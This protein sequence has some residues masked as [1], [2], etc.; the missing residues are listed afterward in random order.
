MTYGFADFLGLLL[1]G[2]VIVFALHQLVGGF[3]GIFWRQQKRHVIEIVNTWN[4]P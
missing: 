3:L 4:K 1:L 2:A